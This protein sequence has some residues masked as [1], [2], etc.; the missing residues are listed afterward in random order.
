MQ[1]LRV[2]VMSIDMEWDTNS[3]GKQPD[4]NDQQK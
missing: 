2:L 1:Q 4:N 3:G